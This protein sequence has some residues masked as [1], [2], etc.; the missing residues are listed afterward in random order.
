MDHTTSVWYYFTKFMR[1]TAEIPRAKKSIFVCFYF[2]FIWECKVVR[3]NSRGFIRF[4]FLLLSTS[5]YWLTSYI[6]VAIRFQKWLFSLI[7]VAL[8]L[9]CF[10]SLSL[11]PPPSPFLRSNELSEDYNQCMTTVTTDEFNVNS[12]HW[13]TLWLDIYQVFFVCQRFDVLFSRYQLVLLA[14]E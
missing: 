6:D 9:F 7:F 5:V 13:P 4:G 3:V 14:D 2:S 12:K 11:P 10:L 1:P 8:C